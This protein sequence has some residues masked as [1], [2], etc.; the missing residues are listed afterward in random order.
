MT[1]P[2]TPIKSTAMAV[3]AVALILAGASTLIPWSSITEANTLGYRSLCPFAPF[4]TLICAMGAN[5]LL[6]LRKRL[7]PPAEE[8]SCQK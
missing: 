8:P 5:T 4:S 7:T 1:T 2:H 6:A 3:V